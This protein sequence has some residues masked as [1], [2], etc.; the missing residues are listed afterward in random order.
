MVP[1]VEWYMENVTDI[2]KMHL[3]VLLR[4][5]IGTYSYIIELYFCLDPHF[6]H[7]AANSGM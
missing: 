1:F 5:Y 6:F 3:P 7:A 2:A 4:Q